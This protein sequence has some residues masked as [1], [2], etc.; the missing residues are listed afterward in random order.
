[1]SVR[2]SLLAYAIAT[3]VAG[4]VIPSLRIAA[5]QTRVT[6]D[7]PAIAPAI[8]QRNPA[9]G[10][11]GSEPADTSALPPP[12][13]CT[14]A[15]CFPVT[16]NLESGDL[17][18]VHELAV[19]IYIQ[20]GTCRVVDYAP[21]TALHSDIE[22][23]ISVSR[24]REHNATLGFDLNAAYPGL[25]GAIAHAGAGKKSEDTEQFQQ[26]PP[27]STAVASG[28]ILRGTGVCFKIRPTKQTSLEGAHCLEVTFEVP[29][30]WRGGLIRIDCLARGNQSWIPG[31]REQFV[32][33][34]SEFSTAV[35]RADDPA[36]ATAALGFQAALRSLERWRT[37]PAAYGDGPRSKSGEPRGRSSE[38]GE[39]SA[40]WFNR[41][42]LSGPCDS[43][44]GVP[45]GTPDPARSAAAEFID[46]QIR[47]ARLSQTQVE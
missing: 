23:T 18:E 31:I 40:E 15:A 41:L 7:V 47:V 38:Q 16:V 36:A 29:A 21:R 3:V 4:P 43:A 39:A 25:A 42:V 35:Y 17:S 1:M 8:V 13:L 2:P 20:S 37:S 32:A 34:R 5:E 27:R 22:G 30:G 14:F 6:F 33:G 12:A 11:P 24:T 45:R 19:A 10:A 44:R 28:T 9:A 46:A 26:Q